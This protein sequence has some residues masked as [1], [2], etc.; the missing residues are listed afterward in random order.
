LKDNIFIMKKGQKDLPEPFIVS[1]D[2]LR[3]PLLAKDGTIYFQVQA[4]KP[5][6]TTGLWN[7]YFEY[8]ADGKRRCIANLK[9]TAIF[10]GAISN[11]GTLLAIVYG[12]MEINNIVIYQVKDGASR[13][14]TLPAQPSRIINR[15]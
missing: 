2:Y 14:I 13:E 3:L 11:D 1:K 4:E 5:G 9:E 15:E 8:S 10:A 7:Q 6:S 12:D